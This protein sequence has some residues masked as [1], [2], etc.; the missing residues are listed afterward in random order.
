MSLPQYIT[1]LAECSLWGYVIAALVD[2]AGWG[3][4]ITSCPV[5]EGAGAGTASAGFSFGRW[6]F[7]RTQGR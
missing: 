3:A 7:G 1:F 5:A 2:S 6:H 4:P